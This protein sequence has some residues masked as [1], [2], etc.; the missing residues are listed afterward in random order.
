MVCTGTVTPT[1]SPLGPTEFFSV[2]Q[3]VE[4]LLVRVFSLKLKSPF[5]LVLV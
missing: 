3:A 4:G 5:K 2:E 1:E